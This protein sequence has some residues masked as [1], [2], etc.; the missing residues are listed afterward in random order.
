MSH[1]LSL[2]APEP[3]SPHLP[4]TGGPGVF[5]RALAGLLD[6]HDP[7][8]NLDLQWSPTADSGNG[9]GLTRLLRDGSSCL[10]FV[11]PFVPG[12]QK[13]EVPAVQASASRVYRLLRL[14]SWLLHRRIIVVIT[15]LPVELAAGRAVSGGDS[16]KLDSDGIRQLEGL[17]FRSAYRLW[18]PEGLAKSIRR[19][20]GVDPARIRTFRRNPY[21]PRSEKD[22]TRPLEFDAGT[23][24]FFYSGSID[25]HVAP[26]FREVLRSIRN[27][28]TTRLHVCGP[29]RDAVREWLAELDV[30]NVRHY[31]LL[32]I[33]EHDWLAQRCDV[34]LIVYPTDDPYNHLRP[35]MKYSAYLANGLAVLSTDIRCVA[36][37]IRQ[38]GVGQAMPVRELALELLRW[39]TR[40]ALWQQ[41]REAA[42]EHSEAVRAG[43]ELKSCIAELVE[44]R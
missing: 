3:G 2:H 7:P 13:A 25:A 26:N 43:A 1:R 32:R 41:R 5:I 37:N 10:L 24:N 27:A 39:A 4:A 42:R 35:T 8:L 30:P 20:H 44:S 22:A 19:Q 17:L 29:D 9:R 33:P 34:G 28:P 21:L 40:P 16:A 31:G 36:D 15:E 14:K 6:S 18:A 12:L 38:D 11:Y 23:V